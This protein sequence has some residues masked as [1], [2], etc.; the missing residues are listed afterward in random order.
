M[1][2]IIDR[3]ITARTLSTGRRFCL[4]QTVSKF[5]SQGL[6]QLKCYAFF[7][8]LFSLYISD[9]MR[10]NNFP[11]SRERS[12]LKINYVKKKTDFL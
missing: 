8:K 1:S 12:D 11:E 10:R 7:G 4:I 5:Y 2:K 6:E 9:K 3:E